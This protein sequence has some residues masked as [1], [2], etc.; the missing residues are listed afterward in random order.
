MF[1]AL[2]GSYTRKINYFNSDHYCSL[3]GIFQNA[4]ALKAARCVHSCNP[5]TLEAEAGA[6]LGVQ[7]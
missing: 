3:V 5:S 1:Y 4:V 7:G 2:L 6:L